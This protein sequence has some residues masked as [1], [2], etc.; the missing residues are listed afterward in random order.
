MTDV[1][2]FKEK[3]K[4]WQT[5]AIRIRVDRIIKG[6]SIERRQRRLTTGGRFRTTE[7]TEITERANEIQSR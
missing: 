3:P 2:S 5:H 1:G 4:F 6:K 7:T